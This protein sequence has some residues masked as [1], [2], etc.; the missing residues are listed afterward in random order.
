MEQTVTA[1]YQKSSGKLYFL[2]G[3]LEK[4]G[5]VD[6]IPVPGFADPARSIPVIRIHITHMKK[7]VSALADAVIPLFEPWRKCGEL[8]IDMDAP[9]SKIAY[10]EEFMLELRRRL[11]GIRL[12]AT[13]LPCHVKRIIP[14]RKL[15]MACDYYV[16]QVHGLTTREG[17]SYFILDPAI[18]RKSLALAQ[19]LGYPFK[20]A[21]PLYSATVSRG[22]VVKP[23]PELVAQLAAGHDVIGFRL[24]VPGDRDALD[25][26]TSLSLCRGETY[27][28]S[29][30]CCWELQ[31]GGAWHLFLRN[32]GYF[33]EKITLQLTWH[34]D[35][36]I[37][38]TDTFNGAELSPDRRSLRLQLP[39]AGESRPYLWMRCRGADPGSITP[40]TIQIKERK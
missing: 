29:I 30:T 39:P 1:Y 9:E 34:K 18:A 23:D 31:D 26:E 32:T 17:G 33:P 10:Y 25:L 27:R 12:S 15:A 38:D 16:L 21:L 40:L 36:E 22:I 13:V 3:E 6:A 37:T 4:D 35:L 2:A 8:Q 11:P 20:V 19:M 28:P 14:F 5:S 24:G 7:S